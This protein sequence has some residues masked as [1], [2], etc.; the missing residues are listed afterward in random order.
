MTFAQNA[1]LEKSDVIFYLKL[2]FSKVSKDQMAS[3]RTL[4]RFCSA[5]MGRD[6]TEASEANRTLPFIVRHGRLSDNLFPINCQ[7]HV[8]GQLDSYA[9]QKL[10]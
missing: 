5:S 6:G 10:L 4:F 3:F 2:K 1:F 8:N 7:K 9:E